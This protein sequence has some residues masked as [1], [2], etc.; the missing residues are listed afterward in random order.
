MH[1]NIK[2][3][4]TDGCPRP[5]SLQVTERCGK[6]VTF[7]S[8]C[9]PCRNILYLTRRHRAEHRRAAKEKPSVRARTYMEIVRID[10]GG[11]GCGGGGTG[12]A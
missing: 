4:A 1:Y 7:L 9:A 11:G 8:A 10:G 2:G 12:G 3:G 6:K 5:L